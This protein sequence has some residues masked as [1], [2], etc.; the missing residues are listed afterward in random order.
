MK[1]LN[2]I[3][4]ITGFVLCTMAT[5]V[6]IPEHPAI[7]G[8]DSAFAILSLINYINALWEKP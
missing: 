2:F 4:A 3:F 7:A 1:V 6:C 8:L 5:A